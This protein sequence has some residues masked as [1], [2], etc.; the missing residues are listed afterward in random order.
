MLGLSTFLDVSDLLNLP[1]SWLRRL[2]ARSI[3]SLTRATHQCLRKQAWI[4]FEELL[5][6]L[7][8]KNTV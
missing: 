6:L 3:D 4:A 8:D 5:S 7:H 2:L 1:Q